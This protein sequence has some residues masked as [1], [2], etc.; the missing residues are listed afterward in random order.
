[1]G[2]P[3]AF[4]DIETIDGDT[5]DKQC[6]RGSS[7]KNQPNIEK[8]IDDGGEVPEEIR[9]WRKRLHDVITNMDPYGFERLTQRLLRECGFFSG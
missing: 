4:A 2:D 3:P 6:H 7:Q 5:I 9:P 1:M 8:E